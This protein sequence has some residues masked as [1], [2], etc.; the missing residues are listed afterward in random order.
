MRQL[1][2]TSAILENS[3]TTQFLESSKYSAS[4]MRD[5]H[6]Y[7]FPCLVRLC[8]GLAAKS[9]VLDVG[10]GNGG[11]STEFAKRGHTVVGIDMAEPGIRIARESCPS[12]KFVRLPADKNLL[13]NLGETPFDLVYS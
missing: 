9:R 10:C 12:G 3:M 6:A 4:G 7:L 5:G 1:E 11:V 13:T 2:Q 8:S